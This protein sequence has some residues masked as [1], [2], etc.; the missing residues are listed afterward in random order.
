MTVHFGYNKK[1]VLDGLRSHFFSRPEIR[2]LFI[3]INV[4]AIVAALLAL[5]KKDS[6]NFLS[7]VF[8]SMVCTLFD[9]SSVFT[10]KY[11]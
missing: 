1:E 7:R 3:L 2:I 8:F 6:T 5:L 4:F 11:L 10:L 9:G